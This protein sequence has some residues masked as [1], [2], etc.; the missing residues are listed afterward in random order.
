MLHMSNKFG[1][2]RKKNY[3]ISFKVGMTQHMQFFGKGLFECEHKGVGNPYEQQEDK[4]QELVIPL[5][6]TL[7]PPPQKS[8]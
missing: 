8:S 3:K 6:E 4:G 7:D 1:L 2:F 5:I